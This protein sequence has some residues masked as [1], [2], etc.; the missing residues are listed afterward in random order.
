MTVMEI[1]SLIVIAVIAAV[2]SVMLKKYNPEYSILISLA[3]G[4]LLLLLIFSDLFPAVIRIKDLL[5]V[6][7]IPPEYGQVLFKCLGICFLAQFSADSC[8]DAGESALAAKIELAG[9]VMIVLLSLP[10]FEQ[11]AQTAVSLIGG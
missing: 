4:I 2:L 9:K 10:L 8:R 6:A 7:Q 5:S 1:T 3:A 11:V